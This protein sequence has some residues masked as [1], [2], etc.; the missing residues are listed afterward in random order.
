MAVLLRPTD[1]QTTATARR[2]RRGAWLSQP[3]AAYETSDHTLKLARKSRSRTG[4]ARAG[5]PRWRPVGC[6]A[7]RRW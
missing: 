4:R 3:A 1:A 6:R 7:A 5:R 2:A